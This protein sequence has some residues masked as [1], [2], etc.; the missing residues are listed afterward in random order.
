VDILET[1]DRTVVLETNA[2]PTIDAAAKY[3]PGFY[4]ELAATIR[5]TARE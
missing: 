4:D 1:D 2:R 3:D 5:K